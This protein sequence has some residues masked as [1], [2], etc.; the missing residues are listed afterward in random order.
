[1]YVV[2]NVVVVKTNHHNHAL[3]LLLTALLAA[4]V[5]AISIHLQVGRWPIAELGLSPDY[6]NRTFVG[7]YDPSTQTVNP[8]GLLVARILNYVGIVVGSSTILI[9]ASS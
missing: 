1:V 2:L 9:S 6:F 8:T 5:L 4:G 3:V 7:S